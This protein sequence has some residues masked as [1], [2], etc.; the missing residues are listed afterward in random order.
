M[1]GKIR[2]F[3]HPDYVQSFDIDRLVFADDL[4]REVLKHI[5]SGVTD[6]GVQSRHSE[7]G[8]CPIITI[9]DLTRQPTLKYSQSLF[10]LNEWARIF[11]LLAI[12]GR[13]KRLNTNVY[14]DFGSGLPERLDLGFNK[15]ADKIAS[16]GVPADRQ[17]E[18]FSVIR[19]RA[20][21][22]NI[23]RF[24][25]LGQYDST[26]SKGECVGGVANRLAMTARFKFRIPRSLLEEV[27]ESRIE[28]TQRLLKNNR[29][30][31]GKEGFLRFLFPFGEFQCGI[32]IGE[33]FLLLL[34]SLAA[35]VQSLIVNIA[36]A[37][38]GSGKLLSLLISRE[39]PVFK[40][41]LDYHGDILHRIGGL[42][43][44]R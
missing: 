19:K 29:T 2:M 8:L 41:L 32:V 14:A 4:R 42:F 31:L 6:F 10:V 33:G 1:P 11:D 16:T 13:S 23:E 25:L 36:R 9:L 12:A 34:P 3:Q 20:T 24:G 27:R 28:I 15:D 35:I 43:N 44:H 30:D 5:P 7:S 18:D 26:I 38:E 21:P 17:I 37:A 22:N 39:E 40:R